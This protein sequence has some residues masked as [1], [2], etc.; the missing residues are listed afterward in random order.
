MSFY[1]TRWKKISCSMI[2]KNTIM[3]L[4]LHSLFQWLESQSS[5]KVTKSWNVRHIFPLN[6]KNT[7]TAT[8]HMS[9]LIIG[10]KRHKYKS[11]AFYAL[12]LYFRLN[13]FVRLIRCPVLNVSSFSLCTRINFIKMCLCFANIEKF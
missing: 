10:V 1:Y 13:S 3:D 12:S 7:K 9:I 4:G 11:T 6:H 8:T 2:N 5:T